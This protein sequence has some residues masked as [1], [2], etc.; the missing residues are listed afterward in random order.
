[1]VRLNIYIRNNYCFYGTLQMVSLKYCRG[2]GTGK[3]LIFKVGGGGR[4]TFQVLC[5]NFIS[6]EIT[7]LISRSVVCRPNV[8]F[9]TRPTQRIGRTNNPGVVVFYFYTVVVLFRN[10]FGQSLSIRESRTGTEMKNAEKING[11]SYV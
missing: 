1:M 6:I 5:Y 9:G 2:V 11:E 4:N 7:I 8:T 3:C 10:T